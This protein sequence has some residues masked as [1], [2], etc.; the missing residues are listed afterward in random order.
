MKPSL[1]C[2]FQLMHFSI[3]LHF[4]FLS[5]NVAPKFYLVNSFK[6][7]IGIDQNPLYTASAYSLTG[8]SDWTAIY[9]SKETE[10]HIH[11]ILKTVHEI[12]FKINK[13]FQNISHHLIFCNFR[14]SWPLFLFKKNTTE[15]GGKINS[16]DYIILGYIL[17]EWATLQ[18]IC[19]LVIPYGWVHGYCQF[20]NHRQTV[21]WSNQQL[22]VNLDYRAHPFSLVRTVPATMH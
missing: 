16:I 15:N 2:P 9:P 8:T 21:L 3:W 7:L 13:N 4:C 1:G 18:Q 22:P 5:S 12:C 11:L 17:N 6:L 10:S 19:L 14:I 20:Q